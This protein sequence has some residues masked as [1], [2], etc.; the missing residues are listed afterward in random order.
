MRLKDRAIVHVINTS[1]FKRDA[2]G[3]FSTALATFADELL[4]GRT[5]RDGVEVCLLVRR[6]RPAQIEQH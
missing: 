5:T 6:H 2:G 4:R 1:S 3:S